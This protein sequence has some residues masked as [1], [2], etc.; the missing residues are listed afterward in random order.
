MA[1]SIY[2]EDDFESKLIPHFIDGDIEQLD[3]CFA[4]FKRIDKIL[5]PS[6]NEFGNLTTNLQLIDKA[7]IKIDSMWI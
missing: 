4:A 7:S 3:P 2:D 5:A 1:I 6:N